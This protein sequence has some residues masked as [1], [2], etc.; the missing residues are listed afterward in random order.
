MPDESALPLSFSGAPNNSKAAQARVH[1]SGMTHPGRV[2]SNNEDVFLALSFDAREVR[3]LG[4]S[5][6][7]TL[8]DQDYIFAVSDGMGGAR[9]GEFASRIAVDKITRL[10]PQSF[11]LANMNLDAGMGD[12]L[13]EL[14]HRIHAELLSLGQSYE[15][16]E[17]MGA[18][19]T[20]AVVTP[21]RLHYAHLGDSRLYYLPAT[22]EPLQQ[23]THDHSYVGWLRRQGQLNEREA[24]N[25]PRK[26]VLNQAMGAGHQIIDPHIGAIRFETGDRFLLC[27]DGIMDG[28]WDQT[29]EGLLRSPDAAQAALPPAQRIVE[30]AVAE[31][32]RDNCTAVVFDIGGPTTPD[33]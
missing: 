24:R 26:N 19:L 9:S 4:K 15:E 21:Q 2:R 18:T 1:W 33:R 31:S 20:L 14:V 11:H 3:F 10:L 29:L 13:S 30:R 16:C 17:G 6:T 5:G 22:G 12:V 8:E 7:A 32:G 27:T 23:I 25:H 28:L